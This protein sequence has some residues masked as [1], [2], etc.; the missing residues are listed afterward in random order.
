LR[1]PPLSVPS[2]RK[3]QLHRDYVSYIKIFF[4]WKASKKLKSEREELIMLMGL[5]FKRKI[6]NDIEE[7]LKVFP[8]PPPP[9][10]RE[11]F[12]RT[13]EPRIHQKYLLSIQKRDCE[14]YLF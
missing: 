5:T 9:L 8:H 14:K 13:L 6:L 7:F 3:A 12:V 1:N 4:I 2:S 11:S 10:E